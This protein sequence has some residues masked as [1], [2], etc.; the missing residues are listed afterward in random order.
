MKKSWEFLLF[1]H[2]FHLH[3]DTDT[4]THRHTGPFAQPAETIRFEARSGHL[5]FR[6]V[7]TSAA[8]KTAEES[9]SARRLASMIHARQKT[10]A[11]PPLFLFLSVLFLLLRCLLVDFKRMKRIEEL[12]VNNHNGRRIGA[13]D[14]RALPLAKTRPWPN[15]T[16]S[17]PLIFLLPNLTPWSLVL[18]FLVSRRYKTSL[19]YVSKSDLE[20]ATAGNFGRAP[21]RRMPVGG[22]GANGSAIGRDSFLRLWWWPAFVRRPMSSTN[23]VT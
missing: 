5:P 15:R 6:K 9:F 17:Q 18:F 4:H 8:V 2:H 20:R 14:D 12:A 21:G 13:V 3:T 10:R 11:P 23:L 19:S 16:T 7:S 22:C 1:F